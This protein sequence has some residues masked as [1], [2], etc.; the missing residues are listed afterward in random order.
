MQNAVTHALN[1]IEIK[2]STK[3]TFTAVTTNDTMQDIINAIKSPNTNGSYFLDINFYL[4]VFK[5]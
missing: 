2:L 3:P 1:H 4:P 5:C